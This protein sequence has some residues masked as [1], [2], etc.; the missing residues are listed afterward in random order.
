[1][2]QNVPYEELKEIFGMD[3]VDKVMS[4]M[5]SL[6]RSIEQLRISRDSWK[7]KYMKLKELQNE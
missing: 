2:Y 1:M 4:I 6:Q 3:A 5:L 7:R